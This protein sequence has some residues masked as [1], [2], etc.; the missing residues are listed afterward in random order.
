MKFVGFAV[1]PCRCS[2]ADESG[3]DPLYEDRTPP[4]P[5][6]EIQVF[7]QLTRDTN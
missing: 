4:E 7:T 2:P 3:R 1:S 5:S 6:E